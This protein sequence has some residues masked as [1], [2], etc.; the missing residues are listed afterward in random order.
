MEK[1]KFLSLKPMLLEEVSKP[2]NSKDYIYELKFDGIRVLILIENGKIV[3]RSRNG[4]ILNE[5]YP[6]LENI[7]NITK[8]TCI[9]DGEIVLLNDGKP[10][11][12]KVMERFKLKNKNKILLMMENYPVTFIVFDILYMN[13]YLTDLTLIERKK[14]LETFKDTDVFVKSKYIEEN[15]KELFKVI[16][17]NKLEGVVVKKKDSKY[18]FDIRSKDWLKIKNW[19]TEEFYVCGY[20]FNKNNTIAIILGE[21]NKDD[22]YYVGKVLMGRK[23][24]LYFKILD[25]NTIKNYVKNYSV[26]DS[27]FISPKYKLKINYIERTKEN[28]LR[29]ANIN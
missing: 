1:N 15:G 28:N 5:V 12:T 26:K 3:I 18:Y 11:F 9:F 6:E 21:K 8:E 27:N 20:Q 13:K 10:D 24:P 19:I 4:I 23:H 2:F 17:K 22:F 25:T 7:K 29:E 14:L 16:K